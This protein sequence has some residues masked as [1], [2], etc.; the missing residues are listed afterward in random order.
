VQRSGFYAWLNQPESRRSIEDK[1]LLRQIKQFWIE[2]GFVYGYRNIT[3]D[4]KD[5]GESG[6]KNRVHRIMRQ[7]GIQSQ[8]GYK[9]HRGFSG[10][11]LSHVAPNTLDRQFE[12]DQ[13]NQTWVTDF[14]YIRTHEGWLYLTIVLDLFSRQVVGW[15]MKN[16]PKADLVIDALL[17]A[18]WR[19]KPKS[20]VLIHSDQGVQYT[21]SDWRKFLADNNLEASM[22]RRGNCHDN[23]VAESFFSLLKHQAKNL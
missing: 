4:L 12:V 8:R 22:S 15:S 23:A 10:G 18:L 19:R 3:K 6:G 5:H 21:C 14:T 13:P 16:S 9:R 7:A 17:M 11:D 1:R 2:S 20:K